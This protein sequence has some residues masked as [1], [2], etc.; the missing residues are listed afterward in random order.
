MLANGALLSIVLWGVFLAGVRVAVIPPESCGDTSEEAVRHAAVEAAEWIKRNQ[1]PDGSYVYL[2]YPE[3]DSVPDDYNEVRHAGVT[4]S[5]YHAA[6]RLYDPEALAVGDR[7]VEWME[8]NLVRRHGWAALSPDPNRAKLG[9][10]ALML[11]ALAERRLATGDTRHDDLMREVGRFI[12]ALQ[13][14]DGGF[15]IAYLF[16]EDEPDTYGTSRYYPGE[17][18]WALALIHEAFPDEGWDVYAR[19]SLHFITTLRDEVE[20]VEFPPLA[21]HWASYGMAEMAEWE[22]TDQQIE[23]AESLAGRFGLLVRTESQRHA[24]WVG[25]LVRG[26]DSRAAGHGTW[27]EGLTSLWRLAMVDPRISESVR[28]KIAERAICASGILAARQ[29]TEEEAQGY[30]RPDLARGAW[31]GRGETRMDDM[32]HALSGL[33]YTLGI[34]HDNPVREPDGTLVGP[35]D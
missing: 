27:V 6:G 34:M 29:V 35:A 13:R 15:H 3:T 33:I 17:A 12:A 18:L 7:A 28:D 8:D 9:A 30:S 32:Q 19:N 1:L 11:V 24:G 23:Y 10:S 20:E 5:I 4:M 2:Y 21:D 22:L 16:R 14:D 26:P 25:S 31:F